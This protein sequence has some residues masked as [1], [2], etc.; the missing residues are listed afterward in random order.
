[1]IDRRPQ[2]HNQINPQ[3]IGNTKALG[4]IPEAE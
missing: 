2:A 3:A 1:V 4:I